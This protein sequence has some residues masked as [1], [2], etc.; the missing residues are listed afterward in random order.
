MNARFARLLCLL[1]VLL[2]LALGAAATEE[3]PTLGLSQ[4][5][6]LKGQTVRIMV[7]HASYPRLETVKLTA[8]YRPNSMVE[9]KEELPAPNSFG[10]LEWAPRESG[11][12]VLNATAPALDGVPAIALNKNV[13]VRFGSF[14]P[15]G[16]LIFGLAILTLF[17]GLALVLTRLKG[18]EAT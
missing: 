11:I 3:K 1:T 16:M 9:F 6:P 10:E 17:G 18:A 2:S 4:D 12:V 14:P 15:A 8:T 7:S 13:S 5:Y